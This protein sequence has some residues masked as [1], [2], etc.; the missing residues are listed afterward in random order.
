MSKLRIF[1]FICFLPS[2][3][4]PG[5]IIEIIIGIRFWHYNLGQIL[6]GREV[7]FFM[8]KLRIFRFI[9]FLPSHNLPG[10]II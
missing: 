5:I 1:R 2:H 8:N 6:K 3:N 10:I 9:G 4:L 7:S